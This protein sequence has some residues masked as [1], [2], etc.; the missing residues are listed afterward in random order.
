MTDFDPYAYDSTGT[1]SQPFDPYSYDVAPTQEAKAQLA[2]VPEKEPSFMERAYGA[3]EAALSAVT[4]GIGALGGGINYLGTLALSRDP[5]AAKAIQESTQ[6][7]LTFQPSTSEGKKD[8]AAVQNAAS[9]L[10]QKEGENAGNR[11][12]DATGSPV[13]AAAA[14]TALNVPQFLIPALPKIARALGGAEEGAVGS[15][16]TSSPGSISAAKA[17]IDTSKA[18]PELAA[19][20][21]EAQAN[22]TLN[23]EAANRQLEAERMGVQ[24]TEGQAEQDPVKISAEQNSR[25]KNPEIAKRFNEQNAQLSSKLQEIRDAAGPEVFSTNPVEHGDTLIQAYK[26]KAAPAYEAIDNA[27]QALRDQNGGKFPI[28]VQQLVAN[29]NNQLHAK[30]LYDH[31]PGP[32]MSTLKR[33]ADNNSMTFENF[34]SMR[35]NLARTMRSSTDGNERAA[36]GVIRNAMEELPLKD[37]AENLKPLAD[38]ARSLARNQYAAEEA[39]PAYSAAV[40]DSVPPDRFVQKFVIGAPRDQVALMRENLKDNEPATQTMAV[41]TIDHL[42]RAAD[43]SGSGNISQAGYNR[44][45][46]Q[47]EPKLQYLAP[48]QAEDLGIFGRV[49]RNTQAQPRGSFVNNSNTLVGSLAESGANIAENMANVHMGGFPGGTI[50]RKGIQRISNAKDVKRI[51]DVGAGVASQTGTKP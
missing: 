51:L 13:L 16:M 47:V 37:G 33:L 10:G 6:N 17:G 32:V 28:D 41:A 26:D 49:A 11:V 45:F 38:T 31:A 34:E 4:G 8:I 2:A 1:Q 12:M 46:S 19:K 5:E 25:G 29:V 24:L 50:I 35:T 44:A 18:S 22:G 7:A 21:H 43:P 15:A 42:K 20:I 30:L 39:D 9:Y 14:N 27:Y 40:N 36:A 23:E 3:G 48:D